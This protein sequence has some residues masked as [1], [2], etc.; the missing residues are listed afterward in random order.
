MIT[1]I[2]FE[3][4]FDSSFARGGRDLEQTAHLVL[5]ISS[6]VDQL[7][8]CRSD[9]SCRTTKE[10]LGIWIEQ[11]EGAKFW[12]RVMNGIGIIMAA[13]RMRDF[14]AI[15]ALT[16]CSRLQIWLINLEGCGSVISRESGAAGVGPDKAPTFCFLLQGPAAHTGSCAKFPRSTTSLS[17]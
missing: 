12:L 14:L 10:I 16:L 8:A 1:T 7:G 2:F 9:R 15:G 5:D 3:Q 4:L 13:R 6:K 17:P 11:T